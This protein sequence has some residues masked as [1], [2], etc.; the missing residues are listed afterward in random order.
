MAFPSVAHRLLEL[1]DVLAVITEMN[2]K[3]LPADRRGVHGI[4]PGSG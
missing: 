3:L 2:S 1:L 4:Y